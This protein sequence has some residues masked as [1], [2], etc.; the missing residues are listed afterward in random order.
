V[1]GWED[2]LRNDLYCAVQD[3]KSYL[4]QPNYKNELKMQHSVK[5]EQTITNNVE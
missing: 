2:S 4:T 5:Q 3:V 1:I